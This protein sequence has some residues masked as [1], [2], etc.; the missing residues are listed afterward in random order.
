MERIRLFAAFAVAGIASFVW[1]TLRSGIPVVDLHVLRLRQV[2]AGSVLGAVLGAS[3][4][5]LDPRLAQYLQN[6]LGF[7][8]TLSGLTIL[9]RA[10][11]VMIFTPI[12]AALASRGTI[13]VRGFLPRWDSCCSAFRIGCSPA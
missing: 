11:A 1:W 10:L 13:D 9:V 7:T 3:L 4:Y 6:S 2:A 5:R 8:A 12:T